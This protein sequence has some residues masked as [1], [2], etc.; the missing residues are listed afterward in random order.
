MAIFTVHMPPAPAGEAPAADKIV[1]LRDGFS[2]PAF[3]FGPFWL[4]WHRAWLPAALWTAALVLI[5]AGTTLVASKDAMSIVSFAMA[6][7]LGFEGPRLL[8]WS[9]ARRGYSERS[10][11]QG[12]DLDEAED[13]FFHDWRTAGAASIETPSSGGSAGERRD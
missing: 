6:T 3:L 8:A 10:V 1:F 7:A 12:D 13:V 11:V 9:L 2:I 4:V 5:G